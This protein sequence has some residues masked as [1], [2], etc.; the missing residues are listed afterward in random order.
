MKILIQSHTALVHQ[1]RRDYICSYILY[2]SCEKRPPMDVLPL[3][4]L[5]L[6]LALTASCD[7][8]KERRDS[9]LEIYK[10]LFEAFPAVV[11]NLVELNDVNQQSRFSL[12]QGL[13]QNVLEDSRAILIAANVQPDDAFP[14]EEKLK[15]GESR[16][17]ESRGGGG[18]GGGGEFSLPL[19]AC[20]HS[21]RALS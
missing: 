13:V 18:G 20:Y 2:D 12:S 6:S 11:K 14:Q 19:S 10:R 16:G 1:N 21:T 3:C 15:E 5:L 4:A 8:R 7:S 17:E 9:S